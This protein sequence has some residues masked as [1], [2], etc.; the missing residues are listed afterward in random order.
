MGDYNFNE[1]LPL[2][3]YGENVVIKDLESLGAELI[4][5]CDSYYYDFRVKYKGKVITYEVKTDDYCMLDRDTGNIFVEFESRGKESGISVTMSDWF[6][7][8]YLHLGEIWYI[9]TEELKNIISDNEFKI[10]QNSGDSGSNT[11]GYLINR[12]RFEKK[13]LIHRVE[14]PSWDIYNKISS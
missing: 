1:D 12:H 4:D 9:R 14:R 5:V 3:Q 8:Y 6:V 7:Y 13:F 2:G 11:K 10:S